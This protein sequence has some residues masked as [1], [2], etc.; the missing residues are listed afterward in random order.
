LYFGS[1]IPLHGVEVIIEAAKILANNSDITFRFCGEGQTKKEMEELVTKNQLK[2]V[3]FLGFVEHKI[4]LDY[5][6]KSDICL[7]IFGKSE[8][9]SI[10]ATHKVYQILCSQKPL[11]TMDSKVIREINLENEKNCMLIPKQDSQK[12]AKAILFLKNNA[13]KRKEIASSGRRIYE[14][15]FSMEKTSQKLVKYINELL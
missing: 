11:I 14:E 7:G 5:I 8:K 1:F 15:K 2:N 4:L 6:K 12:L 13:N 9:A 10:V 3:Q